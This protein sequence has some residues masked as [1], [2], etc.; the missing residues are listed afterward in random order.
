MFYDGVFENLEGMEFVK[1][2]RFTPLSQGHIHA[3]SD[4][5]HRQVPEYK[6]MVIRSGT[7]TPSKI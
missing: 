3:P 2:G 4:S 6:F 7:I 5:G 1:P